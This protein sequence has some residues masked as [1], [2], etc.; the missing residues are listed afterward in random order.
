MWAKC[1]RERE[2]K[3][4]REATSFKKRTGNELRLW[5]TRIVM[6]GWIDGWLDVDR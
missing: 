1:K 4:K 5:F 6:F 2:S 3:M